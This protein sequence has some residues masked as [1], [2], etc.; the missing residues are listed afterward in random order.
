M[1]AKSP[2]VA[3]REQENIDAAWRAEFRRRIADIDS[4]RVQMLDADE[5]DEHLLAELD[6]MDNERWRS[7]YR[8]VYYADEEF[9]NVIAYASESQEP[10]YWR[11]RVG[12]WESVATLGGQKND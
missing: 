7:K 4:G 10:S 11:S 6:E 1:T 2:R 8:V 12:Y 3:S 9:L 5:M